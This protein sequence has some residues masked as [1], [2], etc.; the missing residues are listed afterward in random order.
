MKTAMIMFGS[1]EKERIQ[2]VLGREALLFNLRDVGR[3]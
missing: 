3:Y 2:K 1:D